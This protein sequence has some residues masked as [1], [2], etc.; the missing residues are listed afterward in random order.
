MIGRTATI[1]STA[2]LHARPATILAEAAA[3]YDDLEITIA[4]AGEPV[5]EAMDATSVLSLMGLGATHGDTAVL[6]AQGKGAEDA[7]D[8]LVQILETEHDTE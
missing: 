7:L 8:R 4:A 5:Q 1:A 6:R 3:E 2:G